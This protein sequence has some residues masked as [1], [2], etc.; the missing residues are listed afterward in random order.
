MTIKKTLLMTAVGSLAVAGKLA[1][2]TTVAVQAPNSDATIN[3]P[4]LM[5][6]CPWCFPIPECFPGDPCGNCL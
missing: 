3:E 4:E 1:P 5:A 6:D 2:V